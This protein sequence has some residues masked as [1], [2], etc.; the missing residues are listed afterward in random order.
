M[1]Q[2]Q[3]GTPI[4][5]TTR[6][7]RQLRKFA[8]TRGTNEGNSNNYA[9]VARICLQHFMQHTVYFCNYCGSHQHNNNKIAAAEEKAVAIKKVL[10]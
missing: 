9:V 3:R 5:A 4:I 7:K 2:Q 1:L 6:T 10:H 8:R